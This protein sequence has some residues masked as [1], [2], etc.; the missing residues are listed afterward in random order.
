MLCTSGKNI[1]CQCIFWYYTHTFRNKIRLIYNGSFEFSLWKHKKYIMLKNNLYFVRINK[2]SRYSI[3]HN[4]VEANSHTSVNFPLCYFLPNMDSYLCQ[5]NFSSEC[6]MEALFSGFRKIQI[7]C[8]V[9]K[10]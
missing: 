5:I 10:S 7:I 2:R 9:D 4:V 6:Y 8:V 3:R 1:L